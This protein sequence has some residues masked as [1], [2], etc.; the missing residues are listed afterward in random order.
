MDFN[1]SSSVNIYSFGSSSLRETNP[2]V[3]WSVML[4][5][6]MRVLTKS[7][8]YIYDGADQS[9]TRHRFVA[10]F[11]VCR[12]LEPSVNSSSF[13]C[14]YAVARALTIQTAELEISDYS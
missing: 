1:N 5:P 8:P 2:K 7:F 4:R 10:L 14:V 11:I 13:I 3:L 12:W 9:N 6:A